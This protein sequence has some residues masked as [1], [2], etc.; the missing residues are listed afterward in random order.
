MA[1]LAINK[2]EKHFRRQQG[3]CFA[4]RHL[5]FEVGNELL[6]LLGPSGCGKTTTL[7]LIAGLETPDAGTIQLNGATLNAVPAKDRNIAMVFQSPA[8]F[9][10]LSVSDNIGLGLKLRGYSATEV[11]TKVIAAAERLLI[12]DKLPCD[13]AELSG[14]EAQ[15]VALARAMVREPKLFLLDE[16][17][18][19]LDPPNRIALRQ[20]ISKL[21]K[22]LAVPMLY[23]THD[24]A[25]ATA[26]GDRIAILK[27]GV[28]QQ[29]GTTDVLREKPANDFVTTFFST[30]T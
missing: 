26:I 23:V 2:L 12:R 22:E 27:D 28:L 18:S 8:L 7:R 21:Q 10:H 9:P 24:Q 19:Q 13:P 25:E 4:V 29:I 30:L 17:L 20:E 5:S 1:V 3:E 6:A 14:G 11:Q 16:P 15:R